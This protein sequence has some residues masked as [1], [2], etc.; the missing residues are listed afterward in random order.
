MDEV[1]DRWPD[2]DVDVDKEDYDTLEEYL[3]AVQD[4]K[5]YLEDEFDD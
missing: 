2:N 4:E 3:E 1:R 5:E